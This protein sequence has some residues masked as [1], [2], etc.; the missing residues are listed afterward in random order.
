METYFVRVGLASHVTRPVRDCCSS[1]SNL[2]VPEA[3]MRLQSCARFAKQ[4]AQLYKESCVSTW[5]TSPYL[6]PDGDAQAEPNVLQDRM[7]LVNRGQL[8]D[9]GSPCA[10]A[11]HACQYELSSGLAH[12]LGI[13]LAVPPAYPSF[14]T[15]SS[16]LSQEFGTVMQ[17]SL[18]INC[19]SRAAI[20]IRCPQF[21]SCPIDRI[22]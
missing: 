16:C 19:L 20:S 18:C 6:C 9:A 15:S 3:V 8:A 13:K 2:L 10:A 5:S 4:G 12:V 22:G 11:R 21:V 1:I 14:E 17:A 7:A